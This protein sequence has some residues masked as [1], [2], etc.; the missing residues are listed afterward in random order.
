[1]PNTPSTPYPSSVIP[2]GIDWADGLNGHPGTPSSDDAIAYQTM[3]G[4]FNLSDIGLDLSIY[5]E[6]KDSPEIER[7]EQATVQHR[8]K[9]DYD[10]GIT[11]LQ[12]L[13]RGNY[14][15]DDEGNLTK[16]LTSR[17]TRGPEPNI[18]VLSVTAEG[19]SF[20]TP[21]DD[22]RLEIV[23]LNPALE[24][25]PRYAFLPADV[26]GIINATVSA[27]TTQN[28]QDSWS[29][30]LQI[31]NRP[32]KPPPYTAAN[33]QTIQTGWPTVFAAAWELFQKRRIG[34][35][36]F[37]LPGFRI[38][39]SQYF[40]QP[41]YLNCGGYIEDPIDYGGLPSYFWSV[42]QTPD[43]EDIF[44][45]FMDLNPQMYQSLDGSG[46]GSSSISWLRQCDVLSYSR[47]WFKVDHIWLGA[48]YAQWDKM[49]Y[50]NQDS[51]YPPPPNYP[52]S[53]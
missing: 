10:T 17:L 39:W 52:V 47:T 15:I 20:D 45:R 49:L 43:G 36:T 33:G 32:G 30:I 53:S 11:Y 14:M 13:G 8:F 35:D 38:V 6:L 5:E 22:F 48:P 27:S 19:I 37:Y 3:D 18:C 4:D 29:Q 34:E 42:D 23:E 26:R 16:V 12:G 7:G 40:F 28:L 41:P 1:M 51:P 46:N 2:S 25:H 24:K 31:A 21:P 9:M 50:T 44:T